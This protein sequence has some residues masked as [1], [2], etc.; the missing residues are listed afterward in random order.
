MSLT[1]EHLA[2]RSVPFQVVPHEKAF[3]SIDEA[4]AVGIQADE[5]VKTLLLDTAGKHALAVIPG[6]RRL[7]M[8]RLQRAVADHHAHLA[9]EAEIERDFPGYELGCLPPLGSLLHMQLFVDPDV[10][11]HETVVFAAGSQTESVKARTK[12]LFRDELMTIAP[13]TR[14]PSNE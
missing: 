11:G 5:V 2:G 3:T 12:D 4:R 10:V 7:D 14:G 1:T 6:N 9:T 13:L 8:R